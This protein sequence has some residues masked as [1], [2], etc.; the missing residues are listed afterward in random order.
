M[1]P[2]ATRPTPWGP[3]RAGTTTVTLPGTHLTPCGAD[4]AL[5]PRGNFAAV[6]L[7]AAGAR[8]V[9]QADI[10]RLAARMV[11]WLDSRR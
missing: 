5:P 2:P 9:A 11:A 4:V 3:V 7:L 10:R 1:A 6:D 8:A